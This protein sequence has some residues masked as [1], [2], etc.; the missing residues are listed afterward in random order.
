MGNETN[1]VVAKTTLAEKSE[2]KTQSSH[3]KTAD[4]IEVAKL[5]IERERLELQKAIDTSKL[6]F[7][8]LKLEREHKFWNRNSGVLITGLISF[9]AVMV[10]VGQVWSTS[11]IQNRQMQ[12]AEFQKNREI[13]MIDRQK[14][15]ELSLLDEKNRREWNLSAAKFVADNRK[16]LFEGSPQEKELLAKMIGNIYP[17]NV[18]TS[19]L[20]KLENASTYPEEG[21][22][23][24]ER[25]KIVRPTAAKQ[26]PANN[27][28][29]T[30][31]AQSTAGSSIDNDSANKYLSEKKTGGCYS[32]LEP[33]GKIKCYLVGEDANGC[34]YD[35][36]PQTA[37][38]DP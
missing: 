21:T 29:L 10:S 26:N 9:A 14:E 17:P 36:Y 2:G 20:A 8:K 6:E 24:K 23:R 7:E 18:A 35:C 34:Y 30:R 37:E 33:G 38:R 25:E 31:L 3:I 16:V 22:W 1:Q 5:E 19:L 13:E 32:T 4:E 11:I 27:P 15:K 12:I 28:S